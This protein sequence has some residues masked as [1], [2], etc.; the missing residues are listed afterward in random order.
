MNLKARHLPLILLGGLV[1]S[2]VGLLASFLFKP[3]MFPPLDKSVGLH[4]AGR[5][6]GGIAGLGVAVLITIVKAARDPRAG[7]VGYFIQLKGWGSQLFG[8]SDV[9]DDGSYV[10]TEWF[11]IVWIP[12]FPICRY[13]VIK[14]EAAV[15]PFNPIH[16]E[17]TILE[18]MPLPAATAVIGYA[19]MTLLSL[20]AISF[21]YVIFQ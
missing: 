6:L 14:D 18:K 3:G 20:L 1:G 11:T 21:A 13:R 15:N 17:Y 4:V 9:R 10:A 19:I 16:Q 5:L 2:V 12:I 8:R 7:P